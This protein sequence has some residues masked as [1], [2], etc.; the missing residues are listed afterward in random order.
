[1]RRFRWLEPILTSHEFVCS[2]AY[3]DDPKGIGMSS[4]GLFFGLIAG[5]I[6]ASGIIFAT[7]NLVGRRRKGRGGW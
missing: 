7:E 4:L 5:G 2:L 1:M 6:A 3:R